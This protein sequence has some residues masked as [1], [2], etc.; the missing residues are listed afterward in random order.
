MAYLVKCSQC[1]GPDALAYADAENGPSASDAERSAVCEPCNERFSVEA[2][3]SDRYGSGAPCLCG[4]PTYYGR[5][6]DLACVA[7]AEQESTL[8]LPKLCGDC[9]NESRTLREAEYTVKGFESEGFC[10]AHGESFEV[11]LHG[12]LAEQDYAAWQ[13][14]DQEAG[15]VNMTE[16]LYPEVHNPNHGTNYRFNV[17]AQVPLFAAEWE[18]L[19]ESEMAARGPEVYWLITSDFYHWDSK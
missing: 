4:A 11:W 15:P 12:V 3:G 7:R 6:V 18:D 10:T 14:Q 8:M 1:G 16:C 19:T 5:C 17:M 13:M 2:Y 9:W